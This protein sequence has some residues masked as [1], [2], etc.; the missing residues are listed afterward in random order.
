MTMK[1][2]FNN[3]YPA[4][5]EYSALLDQLF[6]KKLDVVQLSKWIESTELEF[7]M[8]EVNDGLSSLERGKAVIPDGFFYPYPYSVIQGE[9]GKAQEML[10]K[11][12]T[13]A[14]ITNN[15]FIAQGIGNV[16]DWYLRKLEKR[17]K[18]KLRHLQTEFGLE[19]AKANLRILETS[20]NGIDI[21]CENAF[22]HQLTPTFSEWLKSKVDLEN[23]LSIFSV[24][25]QPE[26]GGELFLYD[27]DWDT[28]QHKLN[29][30]TY[31]Q[32]HTIDGDFFTAR[33]VRDPQRK[34]IVLTEGDTIIFRAAQIWHA[35]NKIE[36][37]KNRVTLGFFIA[38]GHDN[39]LYYWS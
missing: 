29:D 22:L 6:D 38:Q 14:M 12:F 31:E 21:H 13:S 9:Q 37:D 32:R 24:L 7:L 1:L 4:Q 23:A 33:G 30:S 25:Q 16:S 15:D 11:Y 10:K 18:V 8:N 27:L 5:I 39:N 28:F 36:G 26:K 35:I 20:K 2:T 34:S 19:F 17:F 3:E